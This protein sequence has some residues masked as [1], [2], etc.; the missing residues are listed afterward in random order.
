MI[1]QGC[2]EGGPYSPV[3]F[4]QFLGCCALFG[5]GYRYLF[6][7]YLAGIW[8]KMRIVD[9]PFPTCKRVLA[10]DDSGYPSF[11]HSILAFF[12]CSVVKDPSFSASHN[13]SQKSLLVIFKV[14]TKRLPYFDPC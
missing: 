11:P 7:Q 4:T 9:I 10:F 13:V 8:L 3:A 2:M 1:D 5:M 6:E 12:D 14:S